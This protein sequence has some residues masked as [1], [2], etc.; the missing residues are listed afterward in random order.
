MACPNTNV[1]C[2][3]PVARPGHPE[4]LTGHCP[5]QVVKKGYYMELDYTQPQTGFRAP[6]DKECAQHCT[7]PKSNVSKADQQKCY[8]ECMWKDLYSMAHWNPTLLQCQHGTKDMLTH[9]KA[10]NNPS[11]KQYLN[12]QPSN[13]TTHQLQKACGFK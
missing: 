1:N 10:C 8:N 4:S 6:C 5:V 7:N 11:F 3:P 12:T 2:P 9:L 13:Y